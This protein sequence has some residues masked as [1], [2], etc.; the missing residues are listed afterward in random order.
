MEWHIKRGRIH[1][2][3][4]GTAKAHLYYWVRHNGVKSFTA[5]Y[6][7]FGIE[8]TFTAMGAP[9]NFSTVG[10]AKAYCSKKDNEALIIEAVTA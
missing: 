3:V 4:N 10:E 9:L 6:Y 7:G 8:V 5:G 2:S 1:K